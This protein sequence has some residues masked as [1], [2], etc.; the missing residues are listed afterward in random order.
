MMRLSNVLKMPLNISLIMC[1]PWPIWELL[2][3][4]Y[5]IIEMR[6]MPLRELRNFYKLT[7]KI[8]LLVTLHF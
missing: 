3:L 2:T 7:K 4:R 1:S 5:K 8:S 6:L